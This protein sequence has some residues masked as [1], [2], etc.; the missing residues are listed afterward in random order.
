MVVE[1]AAVRLLAPWFGS[2][3]VVWTNVI[4]VVLLALSLGYVIG[5][6]LSARGHPLSRLSWTLLAAAFATAWIPTLSGGVA[7][8]F[9]PEG[10][11]LHETADIVLWGSLAASICLFLPPAA[12][13]GCVAPLAVEAVQEHSGG[14]AGRAGGNVLCASTVGSLTGVFSTSHFLLPN[15]GLGGTFHLAAGVLAVA[16]LLGLTI[17]KR[18]PMSNVVALA[19]L[20]AT[21]GALLAPAPKRP[22]LGA[23]QFELA[24]GESPYQSV[25]IVEDRSDA[26]HPLKFLQVNE[27]FDSFQSV[28]QP[29][30]GL[31]PTGFYYNDFALPAAWDSNPDPWRLL[32]L[33]LGAGTTVRVIEGTLGEARE[34]DVLGIEIDP[35]VVEFAREHMDLADERDGRRTVAGL[36]ARVALRNTEGSFDQI[37]LDCY[38]NQVE[39]PPHLCT[40]EFFRE[41]RGRLTDGGWLSVNL[42]GFGFDDPVVSAVARTCAAAFEQDVLV[43]RVP[44]S[45]N[46]ALVARHASELPVAAMSGE[47]PAR[48][49]APE[50]ASADFRPL[51][52]PRELPGSW[53]L[54]GSDGADV[55]TDDRCPIER[56]QLESVRLGSAL[57]AGGEG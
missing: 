42:G 52:G 18:R 11:A 38:A 4:A 56:L 35:L 27:G 45:R 25:R 26:A 13:L 31:L 2:S 51:V 7:S 16:G 32:V 55:L 9:L 41:V 48:L 24:Y 43:M 36:D 8:M 53:R 6:R 39:I 22:T 20:G 28:W 37:V 15:L 46:F 17:A 1:L 57:L 30:V 3:Q 14:S 49:L 23:G 34:L 21:A 54:F 10:L 5:G 19:F 33:G 44:H 12:V 40:V 47:L 29:T 50:V